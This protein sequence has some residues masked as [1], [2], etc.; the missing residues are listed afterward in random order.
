MQSPYKPDDEFD[1]LVHGTS[2]E[3]ASED[4]NT[5]ENGPKLFFP[6]LEVFVLSL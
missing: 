4:A 6:N 5:S 2:E 3:E 1:R